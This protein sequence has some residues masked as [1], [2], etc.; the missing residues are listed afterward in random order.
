MIDDIFDKFENR[1]NKAFGDWSPFGKDFDKWFTD[2]DENFKVEVP[3]DAETKSYKMSY[4]YETGMDEPE[5]YVEG[6]ASEEDVERF[7]KG[8]QSRFGKHFID[9]GENK[10]KRL[11]TGEKETPEYKECEAEKSE[12]GNKIC[13][14]L[15]MPGIAEENVKI[16][17]KDGTL[18]VIGEHDDLKYQKELKL[19]FEPKETKISANNGI[20]SVELSKE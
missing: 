10:I 19:D 1:I 9:I 2:F 18:T 16:N 13:F 14:T 6:D 15:E 4:K 5:I 20:I 17:F 12:E 11:T 3:K 8:V 7:I